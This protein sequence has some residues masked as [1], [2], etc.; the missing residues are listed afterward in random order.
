MAAATG[1]TCRIYY[2]ARHRA[3]YPIV[4]SDVFDAVLN[5]RRAHPLIPAGISRGFRHTQL[6]L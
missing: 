4:S 5:L 2:L 3:G 6:F 1:K